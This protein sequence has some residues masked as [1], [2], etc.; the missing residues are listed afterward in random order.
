MNMKYITWNNYCCN[1]SNGRAV[2]N[3]GYIGS[4]ANRSTTV[5]QNF[6]SYIAKEVKLVAVLDLNERDPSLAVKYFLKIK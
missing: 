5:S 3:D 1:D 2:C 6:G 4:S